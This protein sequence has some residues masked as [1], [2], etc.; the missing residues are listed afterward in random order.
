MREQNYFTKQPKLKGDSKSQSLS[1]QI[2]NCSV[3][4]W[5]QDE[6]LRTPAT[7]WT[8][9]CYFQSQEGLLKKTG[10]LL[11]HIWKPTNKPRLRSPVDPSMAVFY[12]HSAHMSATARPPPPSSQGSHQDKSVRCMKWLVCH[13]QKP[14]N[15]SLNFSLLHTKIK[16]PRM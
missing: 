6:E 5:S 16:H 2:G 14:L 9:Y 8:P 15:K 12:I 7:V 3:P 1:F 13:G 11:K 4:S 10:N